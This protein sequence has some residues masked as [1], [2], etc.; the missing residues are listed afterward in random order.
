MSPCSAQPNATFQFPEPPL[1]LMPR[2]LTGRVDSGGGALP[3]PA[4]SLSQTAAGGLCCSWASWF[5]CWGPVG[6]HQVP[7]PRC[8][9]PT[10]RE[11][12]P[13]PP[14]AS[15]DIN[16]NTA[17]RW[18]QGEVG[19]G[20]PWQRPACTGGLMIRVLNK[21]RKPG[22]GSSLDVPVGLQ[23]HAGGA[24]RTRSLG[25]FFY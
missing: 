4:F 16:E 13:G 23:K 15:A 11:A 7:G 20:P 9:F 3:C 24:G 8:G 6:P 17:R 19:P 10:T 22:L 21:E 18:A 5:H 1:S 2:V 12:V 25:E 14:P